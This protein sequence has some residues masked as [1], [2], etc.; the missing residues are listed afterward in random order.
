M[1]NI[2]HDRPYVNQTYFTHN[3]HVLS[4]KNNDIK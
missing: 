4:S 1:N 2:L 3:V